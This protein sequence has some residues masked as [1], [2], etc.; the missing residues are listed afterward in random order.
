MKSM[1]TKFMIAAAAL[2]I[3]SGVASAQ[4]YHADIPFAFR[5][6]SKVMA[7]GHYKIGVENGRAYVVVSNTE[8]KA[9][10]LLITSPGTRSAADSKPTLAFACDGGRCKLASL[11]V[12]GG[13][14]SMN[15]ASPHA[16]RNEIA[17][18]TETR[19]VRLTD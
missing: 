17:A 4:Q 18:A 15:F 3:A 19:L 12:G 5:A 7:P 13:H 14:T 16:S 2:T 8:L 11:S 9:N 10:S 1:T 6:G